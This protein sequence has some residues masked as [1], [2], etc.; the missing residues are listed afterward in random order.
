MDLRDVSS[1]PHR[2][3]WE[4]SRADSLLKLVEALNIKGTVL[5]I[6]CGDGYFDTRLVSSISEIEKIWGL[7]INFKENFNEGNISFVSD[8]VDLPEGKFDAIF[9]LD[10]LEHIEDDFGYLRDIKSR[11]SP[12]GKLVLT[13]PAFNRIFSKHDRAA[14]H[15]RRYSL[16]QI[17]NLFKHSGFKVQEASYFYASLLPIRIATLN[18]PPKVNEWKYAEKSIITT[19]VRNILNFDFC[20]C[21]TL[22]A[23]GIRLKGLSLFVVAEL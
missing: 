14:K 7:D 2:H 20:I 6:G 12:Q 3:P 11:L 8:L 15:F 9:M 4:L 17:L 16:S 19:L 10:V 22:S 1:N 5:D 23:F 18:R 13:V 21:R